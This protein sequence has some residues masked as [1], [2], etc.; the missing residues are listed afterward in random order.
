MKAQAR[1]LQMATGY[2]QSAGCI[3]PCSQSTAGHQNGFD[4]LLCGDCHAYAAMLPLSKSLQLQDW[5][6]QHIEAVHQ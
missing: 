3:R 5:Y 1:L 2:V 6:K 4:M